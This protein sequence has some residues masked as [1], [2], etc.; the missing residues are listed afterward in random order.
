[1]FNPLSEIISD[2]QYDALFV[3]GFLNNSAIRNKTIRRKY[4]NFKNSGIS[5]GEAIE[6]LMDEYH[7]GRSS[8]KSIVYN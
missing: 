2:G 1:M 6:K 5:P 4:K 7:L 8:I 3:Q